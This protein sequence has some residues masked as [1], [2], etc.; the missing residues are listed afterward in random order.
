MSKFLFTSESVT[1]GHPDKACD[2][3]SDA[4]LD[5][6]LSKDSDAHVACE[7]LA[8]KGLVVISGE[9]RTTAVTDVKKIVL[10][11]IE[12]IGYDKNNSGLDKNNIK[13]LE[14]LDEQSPEIAQ[15]VDSENISVT[16]KATH[17]IY[18]NEFQCEIPAGQL[19]ATMN[20]SILSG[21]EIIGQVTHSEFAPYVTTVGLYSDKYELL[22][23]GKLARPLKKSEHHSTIITVRLD[24]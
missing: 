7:S 10:D 3:F 2:A 12:H 18:E 15:G 17:K 1:E 11:T 9:V 16:Y 14:K 5:D 8:T 22:A 19:N 13:V 23:I 24:F 21:S 4:I 20:P 6:I